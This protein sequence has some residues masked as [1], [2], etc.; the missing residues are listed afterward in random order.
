[1]YV[2]NRHEGDES[3]GDGAGGGGEGNRARALWLG[4][5]CACRC[6]SGCL[7]SVV[8]VG[9]SIVVTVLA[10]RVSYP[11]K[12]GHFGNLNAGEKSVKKNARVQYLLSIPIFPSPIRVLFKW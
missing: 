11:R 3:G 8:C 5:L 1:M 9:V 6:G 2:I 10:A 12:N 7:W 4:F